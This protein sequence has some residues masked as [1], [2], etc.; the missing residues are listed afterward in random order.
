MDLL[1]KREQTQG[2]FGRVQFKLWGKVE[3][4]EEEEA[5]VGRYRFHDA[6]LIMA[7]QPELLRNT[8]Y[9]AGGVFAVVTLLI[10]QTMN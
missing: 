9:F 6:I 2:I 4:N 8:A 5:L 7:F 1:F 3:L 10:G